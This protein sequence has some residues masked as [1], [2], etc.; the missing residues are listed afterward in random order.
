MFLLTCNCG[1]E[2]YCSNEESRMAWQCEVCGQWYDRFGYPVQPPADEVVP[3][4]VTCMTME[5]F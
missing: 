2:L 3:E 5:D 4:H 1:N